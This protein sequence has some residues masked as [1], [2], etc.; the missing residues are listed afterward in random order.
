MMSYN[1]GNNENRDPLFFWRLS[2]ELSVIDAAILI[3]GEDPAREMETYDEGNYIRSEQKTDYPEFQPAFK[4]LRS[5]VLRNKL[6]AFI[7]FPARGVVH[8]SSEYSVMGE[9]V[10]HTSQ[11][12]QGEGFETKV[13]FDHLLSGRSIGSSVNIGGPLDVAK[14]SDELWVIKEPSWTQTTIEVDDLKAWL[15][16][17]GIHPPFFFP[18]PIA[19]EM[20]NPSGARYSPKLACAAA[21]WKAVRQTQVN[22]SAKESLKLWIQANGTKYGLGNDDGIVPDKAVNEIATVCN[23]NTKGGATP[24]SVQAEELASTPPDNFEAG[25]QVAIDLDPEIPF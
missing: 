12:D 9:P 18:E 24:T 11:V 4:A 5:A 14:G 20:M 19:D 17:R 3:I 2:D 6:R 25:R 16:A 22:K 7:S 15:N 21:A 23:W 10:Y 1:H 8:Y 13:V